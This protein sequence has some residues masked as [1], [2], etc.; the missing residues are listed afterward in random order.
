MDR[1]VEE[2]NIVFA[3]SGTNTA[4]T[5]AGVVSATALSITQGT[6]DANRIGNVIHL[7][8][9]RARGYITGSTAATGALRLLFVRDKQP[10][11]ALPAVTDV[12]QS[13]SWYSLPNASTVVGYGG[14]RFVI[15]S[16]RVFN[17]FQQF[18]GT[19]CLLPWSL[20][21]KT[22]FN[23]TYSGNAG[24]IADIQTNN[25]FYLAIATDGIISWGYSSVQSYRDG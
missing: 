25:L 8:R 3:P 2:K 22:D 15:L 21:V 13:A 10:N 20:D 11:G 6:G 14:A 16:D 24:T 9:Y 17:E 7:K 19:S 4:P 12:L 5:T 1:V 18:T 23:V